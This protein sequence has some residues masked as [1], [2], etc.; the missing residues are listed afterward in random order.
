MENSGCRSRGHLNPDPVGTGNIFCN[1]DLKLSTSQMTSQESSHSC[2]P[3]IALMSQKV[4][5]EPRKTPG[6]CPHMCQE[7]AVK[8]LILG[9]GWRGTLTSHV[10]L[11]GA[12]AR[13]IGRAGR[14][15]GLRCREGDAPP[16]RLTTEA[17]CV[18][19]YFLDM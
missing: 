11:L 16:A 2:S 15:R 6:D 13:G 18:H 3:Q 10:E 12:G 8:P 17:W 7:K 1:A 19:T 5:L 9:K 4:P 14:A